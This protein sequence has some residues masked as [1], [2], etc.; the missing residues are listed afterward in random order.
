MHIT[1]IFFALLCAKLCPHSSNEINTACE[2]LTV[3]EDELKQLLSI[4][5]AHDLMPLVIS[6]LADQNLIS[7]ADAAKNIKSM[8]HGVTKS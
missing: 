1:D 6:A 4:A 3:T 5:K 8:L 2:S 7:P